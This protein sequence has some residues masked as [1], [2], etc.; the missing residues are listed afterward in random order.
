MTLE[1]CVH[2]DDGLSRFPW[3]EVAR[4]IDSLH[5]WND[6]STI[7]ICSLEWRER[8]SVLRSSVSPN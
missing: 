1:G 8:E 3:H 2:A 4:I 7:V 5:T 6:S